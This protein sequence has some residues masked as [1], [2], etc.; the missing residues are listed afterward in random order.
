MF[1]DKEHLEDLTNDDLNK[2]IVEITADKSTL[3]ACSNK[4]FDLVRR[5]V[6]KK[7]VVNRYEKNINLEACKPTHDFDEDKLK[8]TLSKI[9][10]HIECNFDKKVEKVIVIGM[11]AQFYTSYSLDDSQIERLMDNFNIIRGV[12]SYSNFS[13]ISLDI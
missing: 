5:Y 8:S 10:E 11:D 7:R 9:W 6:D 4:L 3:E 12:D 2:Y 13:L 1:T